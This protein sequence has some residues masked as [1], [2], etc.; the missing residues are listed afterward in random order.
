MGECS[1]AAENYTRRVGAFYS[2]RPASLTHP[3][4]IGTAFSVGN[5]GSIELIIRIG[6]NRV[7][8]SIDLKVIVTWKRGYCDEKFKHGSV[9]EVGWR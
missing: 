1:S 4:G 5:P 3:I 7:D 2:L 6:F 8:E 9:C